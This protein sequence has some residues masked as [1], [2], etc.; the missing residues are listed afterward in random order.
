MRFFGALSGVLFFVIH[1]FVSIPVR[2]TLCLRKECQL[3]I[4]MPEANAESDC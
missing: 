1:L 3:A 2:H 4:D